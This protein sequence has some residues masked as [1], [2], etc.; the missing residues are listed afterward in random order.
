MSLP[1]KDSAFKVMLAEAV[2]RLEKEIAV[3]HDLNSLKQLFKIHRKQGDLDS[4]RQTCRSIVK[5]VDEVYY[6]HA[7]AIL[8][9]EIAGKFKN[10]GFQS[11]PFIILDDVFDPEYQS[12]LLNDVTSSPGRYK[13]SKLGEKTNAKYDPSIR[14]SLQ[15]VMQKQLRIKFLD[16]LAPKL[17][18]FDEMLD[19]KVSH[20]E[21]FG[22]FYL[23]YVY[24]YFKK[25][26]DAGSNYKYR[27]LTVVYFFHNE[28]RRFSGGDLLLYD[29]NVKEGSS[30]GD[31]T[32]VLCKNNRLVIFPSE[33]FHEVLEVSSENGDI[34]NARFTI[35]G[36]V[37]RG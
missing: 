3:S 28:P 22:F 20:Y 23:I 35:V 13:S 4:A 7:W 29:T 2:V 1:I 26:S 17:S 30:N 18:I 32:R 19:E 11:C 36:W 25:H 21:F 34:Q 24:G 8:N 12:A 16:C 31:F 27:S 33:Y 37:S 14:K 5:H 6:S 9:R 15:G 10:V